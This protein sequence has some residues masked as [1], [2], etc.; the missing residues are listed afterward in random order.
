MQAGAC[1]THFP[2]TFPFVGFLASAVAR[3][4]VP[5]RL[6]PPTQHPRSVSFPY[7]FGD[8]LLSGVLCFLARSRLDPFRLLGEIVFGS[9]LDPAARFGGSFS[10][11]FWTPIPKTSEKDLNR[12]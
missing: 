4:S 9:F 1:F 12:I 11:Q 2:N 8:P 10:D 6:G 7:Q 5:V 3:P